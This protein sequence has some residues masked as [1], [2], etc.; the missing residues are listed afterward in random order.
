[1][2]LSEPDQDFKIFLA[3]G[4]NGD[5]YEVSPSLDSKPAPALPLYDFGQ[6]IA[7]P[8]FLRGEN[9]TIASTSK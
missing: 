9:E 7:C 8:L 4:Y 3:T 2:K 5:L 1:L 6:L